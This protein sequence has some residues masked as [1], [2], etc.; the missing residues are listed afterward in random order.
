MELK[1]KI[2]QM[3]K[4][5][6]VNKL[7]ESKFKHQLAGDTA[8]D[9]AKELSNYIDGV[10][11]GPHKK[12][13]FLKLRNTKKG[14][15]L[16]RMLRDLYGITAK[17]DDKTFYPTSAIVFDNDQMMESV[18]EQV[19]TEGINDPGILKAVFLAGGPG[20]G[21]S[22]AVQN[23]LGVPEDIMKGVSTLGLKVIN[24]DAAFERNMKAAGVDPKMLDKLPND[25]FDK[26]T[27]GPESAREKAKVTTK[28]LQKMFEKERLGMIIDGT[29]HNYNK[30]AKMKKH[31]ESQGYDTAMLFVNTRLETARDRN[32]KRD[33][34]VPDEILTKSW[35]DVQDNIGKFQSLFGNDFK[36]IDNNDKVPGKSA[37][38]ITFNF[39]K[40]NKDKVTHLKNM[41]NEPVKNPLGRKWI[42][43]QKQARGIK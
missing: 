7:T 41:V 4:E 1:D 31:L 27:K 36:I 3:I 23:L 12:K 10:I 39:D 16:V 14:V 11:D 28:K 24:S 2:K 22:F 35:N 9:I 6:L 30:I 21:K 18:N 13:T 37:G 38:E 42:N 15:M 32:Q 40:I 29:G 33:R 34:V 26:L 8:K 20:S 19:L 17:I 5:S 43:L 25:V